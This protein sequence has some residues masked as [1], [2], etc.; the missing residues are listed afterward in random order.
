[1]SE[2][3]GHLVILMLLLLTVC[4]ILTTIY[5]LVKGPPNVLA[6]TVPPW[7]ADAWDI[8]SVGWKHTSICYTTEIQQWNAT[9]LC[10]LVNQKNKIFSS[11]IFIVPWCFCLDWQALNNVRKHL[12]LL[13]NPGHITWQQLTVPPELSAR[14]LL[15][16]FLTLDVSANMSDWGVTSWP[17]SSNT[18]NNKIIN[19]NAN[20]PKEQVKLNKIILQ[21]HSN[22]KGITLKAIFSYIHFMIS[23]K[24]NIFFTLWKMW[25]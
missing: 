3:N 12:K 1:M 2:K 4:M 21:T 6:F 25:S 18:W 15:W 14:I 11:S 13:P 22:Q 8:K 5:Y 19:S 23:C 7:K 24:Q 20:A 16:F 10:I 17:S 9:A